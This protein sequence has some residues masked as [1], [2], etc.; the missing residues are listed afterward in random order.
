M[1]PS[2]S[3]VLDVARTA[4]LKRALET[5]R[6]W[7]TA[8][9]LLFLEAWLMEPAPGAAAALRVGQIRR[10]NPELAA[11]I[12]AELEMERKAAS[13]RRLAKTGAGVAVAMP[14]GLLSG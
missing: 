6:D 4:A 11:E 10:A 13:G 5:A 7:R 8:A 3:Q 12:S 9:D 1:T 14:V 2:H